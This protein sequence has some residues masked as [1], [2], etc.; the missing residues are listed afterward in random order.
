MTP[1]GMHWGP[2]T[3]YF[4]VQD[5]FMFAHPTAAP[6]ISARP[7]RVPDPGT[8]G[9]ALHARSD[10]VA[11]PEPDA[12]ADSGS[13]AQADRRRL[14]G[15]QAQRRR[16]RRR[17]RRELSGV[18]TVEI[19]RDRRRLRQREL[20]RRT[21]VVP[22]PTPAP[23]PRRRSLRRSRRARG[24]E[25]PPPPVLEVAKFSSTGGQLFL[26]WD[27][28]TDRAGYGGASFPCDELIEF[29][30]ASAATCVWTSDSELTASLDYRARAC[31]ATT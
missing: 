23:T 28:G 12:K 26:T 24:F 2:G 20:R 16:D 5:Q 1:S 6:T 10:D 18:R 30:V 13:D 27:S 22:D 11:G 14:Y 25:V 19:V 8:D 15:R 9:A 3:Y 17:L 29:P 7:T 31:P 21:C 4:C